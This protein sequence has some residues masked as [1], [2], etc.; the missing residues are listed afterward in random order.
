[1]KGSA[2][3]WTGYDPQVENYYSRGSWP[4]FQFPLLFRLSWWLQGRNGFILCLSFFICAMGIRIAPP[5]GKWQYSPLIPTLGREKQ[6]DLYKF[7]ASL[8][9]RVSSRTARALQRNPAPPLPP[10][11]KPNQTRPNQTKPNQTK[12]TVPPWNSPGKELSFTG[13]RRS[14]LLTATVFTTR[15]IWVWILPLE[16]LFD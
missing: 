2:D 16:L 11:T 8:L 10:Q 7:E 9:Y 3:P 13:S 12:P 6:A 15:H 1:M 5:P 14:S 4:P